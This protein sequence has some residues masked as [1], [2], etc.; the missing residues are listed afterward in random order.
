MKYLKRFNES[1]TSNLSFKDKYG[2]YI[3]SGDIVIDNRRD[4][5]D[6]KVNSDIDIPEF[7]ELDLKKEGDTYW[8]SKPMKFDFGDA[9]SFDVSQLEEML[10]KTPEEIKSELQGIYDNKY[11]NDITYLRKKMIRQLFNE[12]L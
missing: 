8:I 4:Y 9:I 6:I 10:M 2:K 1:N 3:E 11:K 12:Y 7:E 5:I